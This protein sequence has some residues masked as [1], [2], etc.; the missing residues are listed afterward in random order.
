MSDDV[1]RFEYS[2]VLCV[3]CSLPR[4]MR[5]GVGGRAWC[6]RCLS[7]TASEISDVGVD[8]EIVD[9][10]AKRMAGPGDYYSVGPGGD[11]RR[12]LSTAKPGDT[13]AVHPHCGGPPT[14]YEVQAGGSLVNLLGGKQAQF[15]RDWEDK[16]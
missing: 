7:T 6:S 15:Q 1:F 8:P 11:V 16:G 14:L 9:M 10:I 13:I 12:A 4:L 2:R 5:H 3:A